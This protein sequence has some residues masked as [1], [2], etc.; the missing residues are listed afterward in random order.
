MFNIFIY[1]SFK[2]FIGESYIYFFLFRII[3]DKIDKDKD[4]FVSQEELKEWIQFT[5]KRYI[6]DDINRQ[7]QSHNPDNKDK[8]TWEE[9]KKM[10]YGFLDGNIL[11]NL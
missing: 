9:Y 6:V 1:I 4:G 5:Q 10:V 11:V 7:W 2:S 8:I 3:V